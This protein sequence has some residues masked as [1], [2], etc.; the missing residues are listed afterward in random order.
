LP[1]KAFMRE[2]K[3]VCLLRPAIT[4]YQLGKIRRQFIFVS[5]WNIFSWGV[6][7]SFKNS[8][9]FINGESFKSF[10]HAILA[11]PILSSL[12]IF[13]IFG[14]FLSYQLLGVI[15]NRQSLYIENKHFIFYHGPFMWKKLET[16]LDLSEIKKIYLQDFITVASNGDS[17]IRYRLVFELDET[18]VSFELLPIDF[19][20]VSDLTLWLENVIP[21]DLSIEKRKAA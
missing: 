8:E 15:F 10:T 7:F 12:F 2:P 21:K 17:H 6:L 3:D 19:A 18:E 5:F 13:P 1:D 4:A 16:R 9:I 20:Q 14:L 11:Y